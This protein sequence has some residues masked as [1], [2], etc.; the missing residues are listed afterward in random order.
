[1][2]QAIKEK[3][4]MNPVIF[5]IDLADPGSRDLTVVSVA[6]HA[7][8]DQEDPSVIYFE[9]GDGLRLIFRDGKYAGFYTPDLAEALN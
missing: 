4:G 8:T 7:K 5:G 6:G 1:M 3:E 9:T 2:S